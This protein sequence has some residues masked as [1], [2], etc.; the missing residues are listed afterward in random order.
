MTD[1]RY[2]VVDLSRIN[3]GPIL[4]ATLPPS[5]IVRAELVLHA[6]GDAA[7][8]DFAA[9]VENFQRDADPM[10]ELMIWERMASAFLSLTSGTST[11]DER[12]AISSALLRVSMLWPQIRESPPADRLLR[13]AVEAFAIA[14]SMPARGA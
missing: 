5:F 13:L 12:R 3:P 4:H 8:F 11:P 10:R 14:G 9:F 6:F 2:A 1:E 7:V